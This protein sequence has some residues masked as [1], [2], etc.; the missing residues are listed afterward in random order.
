MEL[1]ID[2]PTHNV[3]KEASHHLSTPADITD[4]NLVCLPSVCCHGYTESFSDKVL[5]IEWKWRQR[6]AERGHSV[7]DGL[8]VCLD[9]YEYVRA[10]AWSTVSPTCCIKLKLPRP[11]YSHN[12]SPIYKGRDKSVLSHR[13]CYFVGVG[14]ETTSSCQ[15]AKQPLL[16]R[17]RKEGVNSTLLDIKTKLE[18]EPFSERDCLMCQWCSACVKPFQSVY[19]NRR[20]LPDAFCNTESFK[21]HLEQFRFAK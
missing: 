21:N 8:L 4:I 5:Q 14:M 1:H 10:L 16:Q 2:H 9:G 13:T 11:T 3:S 20:L 12:P 15:S 17:L 7:F 6:S 19:L 18:C